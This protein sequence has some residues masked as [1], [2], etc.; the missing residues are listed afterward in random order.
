VA[1][2]SYT[3]RPDEVYPFLA[4]F[5]EALRAAGVGEVVVSPG[6]RSTPLAIAADRTA[7]LR[8]WVGLDERSAGFFA[9]G[10]AKAGR[11]PAALVCTSGTA[12]A[13]Y[14]PAI[15]EAH[16]AR[17]PLVVATADRPPE[18][19]DWGAGQTIEQTGLY[20]AHV[21]WAVEVPMAVGG[22]DALRYAERLGAR[23]VEQAR[24]GPAGPVHLNWP[25]REPLAPADDV[26][27][28]AP[29]RPPREGRGLR[30]SRA[31]AEADPDDLRELARLAAAYERGIVCCG[32]MDAPPALQEAIVD[33]ARAAR[34]PVLADPAS[35]LRS[36]SGA[37]SAP[38]LDAGDA[39]ARVPE[40]VARLRPEVVLRV[41]DTPVSK[42]QRLWIEAAEPEAV[43]WLD[44]GGQWGEPSHRATRVV[45]G[46]AAPLL[47]ET[48]SRLARH[49]ERKG[50]WCG[51]LEALDR[52][53]RAALDEA[54][55]SDAGWSGLAAAAVVAGRAPEDALLFASNSMSIR[56]L[57]LALARRDRRLRVL[58]NRGASGIDGVTSTALGAAAATRRP[59]LLLTGDLAFLHDLGGLL[60]AREASIPATI[61][62]LDDDG[63]GIFS[64]LPIAEQGEAV[65]FERLFR[66]P[67]GLDLSRAAAL[68]DL[69]YH[70]ATS[71]ADLATA[72]DEA[73]SRPGVSVVHV[74][75]E[76]GPN[77]ARFRRALASAREAVRAEIAS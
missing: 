1:A 3:A 47:A 12:A 71:A 16:H 51:E 72:L 27:D 15:V 70:R 9:L 59:T 28:A 69:D 54:V 73:L 2:R 5:F 18:L 17:V 10:L 67:H 35:Q 23:A 63:G 66:T 4:R 22:E 19:R 31:R 76:A 25:F 62:V 24:G 53:A 42:A 43:W 39:F 14:L 61:V 21:R 34:W 6:S 56:L 65:G 50:D 48:A 75:L 26:D 52:R 74:P 7:G 38:I 37:R 29:A 33:F 46:G 60:F 41:G 44:E 36:A 77:E 55:A 40:V 68:Y 8:T 58:C 64:F 57:D 20:G 49:V 30:F 11:R 13:N 45:R 32:P